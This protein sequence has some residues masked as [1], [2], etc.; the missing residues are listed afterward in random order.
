MYRRNRGNA[1]HKMTNGTRRLNI[2]LSEKI[3]E[4][5]KTKTHAQPD[6]RTHSTGHITKWKQIINHY[7]CERK[8]RLFFRPLYICAWYGS[9]GIRPI[10][11]KHQLHTHTKI[12]KKT[13]SRRKELVPPNGIK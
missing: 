10:C 12:G 8:M 5:T 2:L 7:F 6:T 9:D 11:R 4:D 1:L 13:F 3:T